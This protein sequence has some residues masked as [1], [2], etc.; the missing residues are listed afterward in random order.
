M[1]LILSPFPVPPPTTSPLPLLPL[2]ASM[3][4]LYHPHFTSDMHPYF[5]KDLSQSRLMPFECWLSSRVPE[6]LSHVSTK[7]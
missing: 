7:A 3:R 6:V 1:F 4:V 5:M 2:P